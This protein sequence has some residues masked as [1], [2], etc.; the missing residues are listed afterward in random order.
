MR[1][2]GVDTVDFTNLFRLRL[3]VARHGEMDGA[4]WWN[5]QGMLGRHGRI[6]LGRG[7][8]TTHAFAQAR[9]VFA[10]ARSRCEEL[11]DLSGAVTLW[12]LPPELEDQFESQWQSWLDHAEAWAPLFERLEAP[13]GDDLLSTLETFDLITPEQRSAAGRLRRGAEGRSVSVTGTS[14]V[15]DHL[16]TLLAAGFSRGEPGSLVVPFAKLAA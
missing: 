11:F 4:R 14:P 2:A 6:V 3:V 9:V 16:L 1:R 12:K 7:F 5:T 13:P 8:P 15:D 10:V